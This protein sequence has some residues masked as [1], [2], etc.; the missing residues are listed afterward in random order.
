ML[1]YQTSM[2]LH[3]FNTYNPCRLSTDDWNEKVLQEGESS[4][5]LRLGSEGQLPHWS[6]VTLSWH[7]RVLW[8][9]ELLS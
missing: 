9:S 5:G 7:M 6:G 3:L 4:G 8:P 2:L 1:Q